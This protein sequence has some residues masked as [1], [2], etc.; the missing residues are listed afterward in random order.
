MFNYCPF[1]PFEDYFAP[2][3]P[4]RNPLINQSRSSEGVA[5]R[6]IIIGAL[7]PALVIIGSHLLSLV[8][9]RFKSAKYQGVFLRANGESTWEAV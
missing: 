2:V 6:L 8:S 9:S 5:E 7:P 4:K 3:T 1:H